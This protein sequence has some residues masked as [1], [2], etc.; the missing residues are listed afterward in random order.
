M[1]WCRNIQGL[2]R[3]FPAEQIPRDCTGIAIIPWSREKCEIPYPVSRGPVQNVKS[4]IPYPVSR[5]KWKI[6]YPV[7]RGP[8][9]K[10]N[11][12]PVQTRPAQTLKSPFPHKQIPR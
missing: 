5:E 2:P 9:K 11:P 4:R 7:S 12:V 10:A 3:G 1:R 8:V 6:P